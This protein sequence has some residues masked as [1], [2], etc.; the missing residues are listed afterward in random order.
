MKKIIIEGF[1]LNDNVLITSYNPPLKARVMDMYELESTMVP[2]EELRKMY[3]NKVPVF[4]VVLEDG[5]LRSFV[6]DVVK[7]A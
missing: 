3:P 6:K 2:D 7:K 5:K 1:K 4:E